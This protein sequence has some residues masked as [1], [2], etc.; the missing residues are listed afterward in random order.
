MDKEVAF[1]AD[2][3]FAKPEISEELEEGGEERHLDTC[4]RQPAAGHRGVAETFG[5]KAGQ[6]AVGGVQE[7]SALAFLPILTA[8]LFSFFRVFS[9]ILRGHSYLVR[10]GR[11]SY[12]FDS[13]GGCDWRAKAAEI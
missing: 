1:R 7:V 2:A 11:F 8:Q 5:G 12:R 6:K 9:F 13:L 4:Q 10:I 3:A